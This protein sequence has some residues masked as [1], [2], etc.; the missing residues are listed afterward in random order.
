MTVQPTH[1][2]GLWALGTPG[3]ALLLAGLCL[4]LA[5]VIVDSVRLPELSVDAYIEVLSDPIVLRALVRTFAIAGVVTVLAI[6]GGYLIAVT[7]WLARPTWAIIV[8][9]I[10]SSPILTSV[11]MRNFAWTIALGRNGPLNN[12]LLTLGLIDQPLSYLNTPTAVIIGMWHVM[13]P[14]AVLPIFN[15]LMKIDPVLLRASATCGASGFT[16][17]RRVT[18][19]LSA[20]GSVVAGVFVFVLSLGFFVTPALLGGPANAMI[21]NVVDKEANFYLAFDKAAAISVILLVIVVLLVLILAR[22]F[23][24]SRVL[25]G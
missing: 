12:L 20:P 2:W 14:F 4:P 7:A 8:L 11:V 21:A 3:I 9:L 22:R 24:V 13:L 15:S 17:F 6:I 16:T 19:P 5:L 18:L 23:D 1:R 10:A 25:R